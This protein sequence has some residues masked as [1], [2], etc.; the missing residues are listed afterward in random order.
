[1]TGRHTPSN[2]ARR[3]R[4][5]DRT[6]EPT[7]GRR[8]SARSVVR[9]VLWLAALAAVAFT[10][11]VVYGFIRLDHDIDHPQDGFSGWQC[12]SQSGTCDR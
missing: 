11:V 9:V 4:D 8:G 7:P 12:A 6:A 5:P 1:M 10:V 3:D 2:D